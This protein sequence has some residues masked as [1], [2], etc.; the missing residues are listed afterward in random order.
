MS[1][2]LTLQANQTFLLD[3]AQPDAD[4]A[5]LSVAPFA[6]LVK[7]PGPLHHYRLTPLSLWNAAAAGLPAAEI[8]ATL[9][10]FA[11]HPVP[12][13]MREFIERQVAAYGR[14]WLEDDGDAL[15][16]RSNDALLLHRVADDPALAGLLQHKLDAHTWL[17]VPAQRGSLKRA[18]LALD[19]P[20][21]DRA[22]YR[23]GAPLAIELRG[24]RLALRDY[25]HEAVTRVVRSGSGVVVLPCGAGKT[26]V[27][28]G[29]IAAHQTDTLILT[30]SIVAARQW[31]AELADK[32][33]L[34]AEAIGEYSGERK[35][36]R[37]V[38]LATY[39][40]LTHRPDTG[41]DERPH[42]SLF[43]ARDW[44]L[45]IYDE[46]HLLPAPVF[47]LVADLQATLRLGLTA[48]LVREDALE[49]DVF[50]LIGPTRYQA[51][52]KQLE[53][54]G[55]IAEALCTEVRVALDGDERLRY[56]AA[57]STERARIAAENER[58]HGVVRRL[59]TQH[60][61]EP[62]LVIGQYLSQLQGI[63]AVLKAPLI[64]GRTPNAEREALYRRFRQGEIAQL[65]VSKVAN[66][67][68]DL[69]DASVA[70]Q[71]SGAFGSRQEEAQRLGRILR[72]KADGKQAHFYTLVSTD[73]VEQ[74]HA[75]R[76]Q[77]FLIEQGYTYKIV[78]AG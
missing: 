22:A 30:P 27:G 20:V 33:T 25:Q 54:A 59:A 76:R 35:Q 4:A 1:S 73:T 51:G 68:I 61:D 63:A 34:P 48:T 24:E 65:V 29:L 11:D 39:Q 5:H 37:P 28:I 13:A 69:P 6:E 52:W 75:A 9:A 50:A 19:C 64:S 8:I 2:T 18:L 10:A 3:S 57:G 16:L 66:Y 21:D 72:P 42:L 7:T 41:S 53:R 67:A 77:R 40:A 38:T 12:P 71:V 56:S 62:L 60:R 23:P 47:R 70:I 31:A 14:L 26:V 74:V 15:L 45:I 44:G 36:V 17:C 43:R 32:T 55:W 46:V 49:R 78:A 58:K